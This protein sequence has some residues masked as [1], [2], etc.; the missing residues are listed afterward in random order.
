MNY[1]CEQCPDGEAGLIELVAEGM[2]IARFVKGKLLEDDCKLLGDLI[3]S[4]G[5]KHKKAL[6]NG[7]DVEGNGYEWLT[8]I[9]SPFQDQVGIYVFAEEG[10][11]GLE[12]QY[13][14]ITRRLYQR[15]K[16]H[17]WGKLSNQA[18]FAHLM[19][20]QSFTAEEQI[21]L[22]S[23]EHPIKAALKAEL[24]GRRADKQVYVKSLRVAVYNIGE[25][26]EFD[27]AFL[28]MVI[29]AALTSHWNSF[30]TH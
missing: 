13:V 12:V 27:L 4:S 26:R 3:D 14:G 22:G 8:E 30:K 7:V 23:D 20:K 24:E 2:E 21:I 1:R 29:A 6:F 28:E 16:E 15:L 25:E 18:T 19:A 11:K 5:I 17:G 9:P 10:K